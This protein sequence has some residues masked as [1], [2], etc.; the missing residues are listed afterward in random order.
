[1]NEQKLELV[2]AVNETLTNLISGDVIK[3]IIEKQLKQTITDIIHSSMRDYS[4]FGKI[5]KGK[6]N[7]VVHLAACNVELPEYTKF[8]SD[9][10][11]EQFDTVLQEQ[12]KVQLRK[13]ISSE[14]GSLPTGVVTA[15]QL[16]EKIVENFNSD[17]YE[18]ER[19]ISVSCIR[20][21]SNVIYIEIKDDEENEEIK[22]SLYNHGKREHHYIGYIESC[23][24][25]QRN[26]K[27][28]KRSLNTHCM[29]KLDRF[30]YR[31]YCA[32]TEIDMTEIDCLCDFTAGGYDH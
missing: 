4:D 15:N 7:S 20:S 11:I 3:E 23:G 12:S 30:L 26:T 24:W 8:V 14:L 22:L 13:L 31:L 6:I 5:I 27:V 17:E 2:E 1:M 18:A 10:V 9:V 25:S 19:E 29:D 21:D 28:S 16:Q 32:Q